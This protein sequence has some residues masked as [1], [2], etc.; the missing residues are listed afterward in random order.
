M[1]CF[2]CVRFRGIGGW[3]LCFLSPSSPTL[4]GK[5]LEK[6]ELLAWKAKI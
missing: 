6:A 5:N 4:L 3:A 2:V 1:K